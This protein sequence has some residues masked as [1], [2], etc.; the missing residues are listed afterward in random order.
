MIIT[1]KFLPRRTFLRGMG[2]TLAQKVADGTS[3]SS[4][5]FRSMAKNA[6][7]SAMMKN[8]AAQYNM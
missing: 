1:K 2:A 3:T 4:P 7:S 6:A 8:T 5:G